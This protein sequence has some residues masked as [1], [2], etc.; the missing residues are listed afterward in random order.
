VEQIEELPE[1]ISR[2]ERLREIKERQRQD[3]ED[4][5]RK[6]FAKLKNVP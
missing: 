5:R 2:S 1:E 6:R 4:Y 3:G